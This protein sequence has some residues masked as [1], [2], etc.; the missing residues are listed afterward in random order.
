MA[1]IY[2]LNLL[3]CKNILALSM[4]ISKEFNGV[5]TRLG[6]FLAEFAYSYRT[7]IENISVARIARFFAR[8]AYD[9]ICKFDPV[10]DS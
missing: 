7:R 4:N 2:Y 10:F 3:I 5:A 1:C 9:F 8:Y 6:R